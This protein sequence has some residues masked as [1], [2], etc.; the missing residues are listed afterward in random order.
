[1]NNLTLGCLLE[2]TENPKSSSHL[3]TWRGK[4][5]ELTT[6]H[7]MAQL[8]RSEEK[9]LGVERTESHS[10]CD[11]QHPLAGDT[12]TTTTVVDFAYF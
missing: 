12:T 9:L 6:G 11:L 8:W 1:M 3:H 10:V 2:L 5:G 7:L 4:G